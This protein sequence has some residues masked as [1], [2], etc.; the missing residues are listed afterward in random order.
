MTDVA[1]KLRAYLV[2]DDEGTIVVVASNMVEAISLWK[3]W[4][5]DELDGD[6]E[7]P[8]HPNSV[9]HLDVETVLIA[10]REP[11]P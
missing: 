3:N 1:D 6:G 2:R 9:E 7:P 8:D 4:W 11:A 5:I 10:Q